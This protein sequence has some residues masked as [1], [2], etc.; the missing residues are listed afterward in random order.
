MRFKLRFYHS[1]QCRRDAAFHVLAKKNEKKDQ[2]K[3]SLEAY[4]RIAENERELLSGDRRAFQNGSARTRSDADA[5][6][7]AKAGYK[8]RELVGV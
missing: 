4:F 2:Y 5:C 6:D 3:I 1:T 8:P 7:Q